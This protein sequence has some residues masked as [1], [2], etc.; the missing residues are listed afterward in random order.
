MQVEGIAHVMRMAL[1][2][3]TTPNLEGPRYTVL[4]KRGDYEVRRYE[5][6]LIAEVSMPAGSSPAAGAEQQPIVCASHHHM[7]G[8]VV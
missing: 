3:L 2:P 6:Y 8:W 4:Q 1:S 7:P 5:P